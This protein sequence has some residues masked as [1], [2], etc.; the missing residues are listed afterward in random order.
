MDLNLDNQPDAVEEELEEEGGVLDQQHQQGEEGALE[1]LGGADGFIPALIRSHGVDA[2]AKEIT[3]FMEKVYGPGAMKATSFDL[4]LRACRAHAFE[5]SEQ[6]R[7]ELLELNDMVSVRTI[8]LRSLI[9]NSCLISFLL[10]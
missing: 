6:L 5:P 9:R 8:P 7:I 4:F 10:S 3:A 2:Y 1:L